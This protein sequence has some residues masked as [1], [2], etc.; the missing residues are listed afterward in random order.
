[1]AVTLVA[2]G[3]DRALAIRDHL[4]PVI[5]NAGAIELQRDTLRL[6]SLQVGPWSLAH[7]TPFNEL[8]AGEASSPG[9]RHALERQQVEPGL[10]YGIEVSRDGVKMLVVS[11]ADDG[12]SKIVA[13]VRG[14]WEDDALA[15]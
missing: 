14:T 6:I 13:F 8:G 2:S 4:V 12:T 10:P 11:W 5:R 3:D 9:Y 7:W 1:M 15:L